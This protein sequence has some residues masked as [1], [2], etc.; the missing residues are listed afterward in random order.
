MSKIETVVLEPEI[1]VY[2]SK[3]KHNQELLFFYNL[4]LIM[5]LM[6]VKFLEMFKPETFKIS[7]WFIA[8]MIVFV[9]LTNAFS[10]EIIIN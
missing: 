1:K 9:I 3:E 6:I 10:R 4:G 2:I 8:G 5:A 7:I